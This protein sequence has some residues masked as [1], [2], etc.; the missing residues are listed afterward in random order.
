MRNGLVLINGVSL[1]EPY[2]RPEYRGRES[3]DWA[4]VAGESYFVLG[5]NR[6]MSC[7]SRRWGLVRRNEIIGRAEVTYWPP[8]RFGEP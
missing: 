2:L 1:V 4:R 5:D 8:T 6:T 7:D 3:G